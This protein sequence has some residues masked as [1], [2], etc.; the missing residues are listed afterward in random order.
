MELKVQL[1]EELMAKL[2]AIE[3]KLDQVLRQTDNYI[4]PVPEAASVVRLSQ[5]TIR[6]MINDGRIKNYGT[7]KRMTVKISEVRDA[8]KYNLKTQ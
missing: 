2:C 1:P 8:R 5:D 3:T 6:L 7:A 4:L